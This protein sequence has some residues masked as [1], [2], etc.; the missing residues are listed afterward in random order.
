MARVDGLW[1]YP[2]KSLGGVAVPS[3]DLEPRGFA[4]DRRWMIV[5]AAGRF[6]TRRG[7]PSLARIGLSLAGEGG[8]RLTA[9]E[10]EALLPIAMEEGVTGPV[11]VWRDD[12]QAVVVDNEASALI[13][14]VAGRPLRLAFM[15]EASRRAV[16]AAHAMPGEYVS[17]ADGFPLLVTTQVSLAALNTALDRPVPMERFRPN[18]VLTGEELAPWAEAD[19][20]SV[21]IGPVRLRLAKPCARCI[22]ITQDHRTGERAEG[23]AVPMALRRL[24]RVGREGVLFGM[25][26]VP[27]VLGRIAVG[28]NVTVHTASF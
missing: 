9:P 21:S 1:I 23:N 5:D 3:T 10:G 18:I 20:T 6:V 16:D 14:D 11:R 25:N 17:F 27:E 15:P 28:D 8:Y 2:V 4:G 24:G 19:W 7:V 22:V 12:V 26:A 13:S